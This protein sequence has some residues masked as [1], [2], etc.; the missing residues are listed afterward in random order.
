[1][2]CL[3]GGCK[4][5]SG[6]LGSSSSRSELRM[7]ERWRDIPSKRGYQVSDLGRVRSLNRIVVAATSRRSK[8]HARRYKGQ[9]LHPSRYNSSGHL[10]IVLGH[11]QPGKPVHQLVL[12]AFRGVCPKGKESLHRNGRGGDN[13][14]TNLRYGTRSENMADAWKHGVRHQYD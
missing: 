1:V 12:R 6:Y 13:R 9:I 2:P 11:G 10:S 7:K 5:A 14:L 3:R 8:A 4:A